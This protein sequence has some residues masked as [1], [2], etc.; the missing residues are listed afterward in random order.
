MPG[1]LIVDVK[2]LDAFPGWDE[3]L[4]GVAYIM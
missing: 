1:S 4:A 3:R 2:N